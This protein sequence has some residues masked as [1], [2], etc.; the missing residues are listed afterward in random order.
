MCRFILFPWHCGKVATWV[1]YYYG[2][3]KNDG[4]V[5]AGVLGMGHVAYPLIPW[6]CMDVWIITRFLK[7]RKTASVLR[8]L[9]ASDH[10]ANE[11]PSGA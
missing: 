8:P 6:F 1:S 7:E 11:G 9:K 10:T 2:G 5:L 3:F 4:C